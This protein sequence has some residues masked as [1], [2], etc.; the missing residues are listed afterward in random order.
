MW[1]SPNEFLRQGFSG[2]STAGFLKPSWTIVISHFRRFIHLR[3]VDVHID[4]I[5]DPID[6]ILYIASDAGS[7]ESINCAC[8]FDACRD[9]YY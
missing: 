9:W 6:K 2:T 7:F 1:Q 3:W 8:F 5:V 4:V